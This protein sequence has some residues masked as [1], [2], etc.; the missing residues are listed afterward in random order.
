MPKRYWIA[1]AAIGL[2]AF[3]PVPSPGNLD[4]EPEPARQEQQD[5]ADDQ[6]GVSDSL[7]PGHEA[8]VEDRANE[9]QPDNEGPADEDSGEPGPSPPWWL[10]NDTT[11]QAIMAAATVLATLASI[12]AVI[13]LLM[14]LHET[15]RIGRAQ[16]RAYLSVRA[17]KAVTDADSGDVVLKF[18]VFNCGASPAR[19]VVA[20][21]AFRKEGSASYTIYAPFS[22]PANSAEKL[23]F[24]TTQSNLI[25]MAKN[26][27]L[28][29]I[30]I[31]ADIFLT[32]EDVFGD[33]DTARGLCIFSSV[34]DAT[35][36]GTFKTEAFLGIGPMIPD[37]WLED[38]HRARADYEDELKRREEE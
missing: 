22:L 6:R 11:A 23:R 38:H 17:M 21:M 37:R 29:A 15:R 36:F 3:T 34:K 16:T 25:A 14:T 19:N 35:E 32:Y 13:L 1:L 2:A 9:A 20:S 18:E 10:L 26:K 33:S 7:L 12:G 27:K 4:A 5:R 28:A 8:A 31:I 30:G 24:G